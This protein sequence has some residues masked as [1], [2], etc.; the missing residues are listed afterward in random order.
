MKEYLPFL[1]IGITA[2]S[3][4]GLAA[5][6]LVLT[7]KTSGIFN[8]AH[9]AQAAM[10]AYLMFEFHERMGMPWPLA[11]L[12]SLLLAGVVAGL[13]LER[14]AYG[15]ASVGTAARVA[16]TV[17]LLVAIQGSL[18]VAFGSASIGMKI[19]L[20]TGIVELPGVN[21]R[22]DQI[23]VTTFVLLAVVSLYV[24]FKRTKLGL[25]M[26][27]VVDDPALLG[28]QS[29]NPVRVRR[30]AWLIG[31]SFAAISGMVLAPTLGLDAFLLTLLV[32]YAYGAAAVGRF[33]SLPITYVGGL[34]I[35]VAAALLTKFLNT[36]GPIASLPATLPFLVLFAALL[37]VP[38]HHLIERGSQAVRRQLAPVAF[39][40]R[41]KGI[42][43]AAGAAVAV[44]IPGVVGTKLPLFTTALV[45]V[46]LFASLS[47]LVRMSG[48]V[49][50]CQMAFAAVGATTAARAVDAGV[51]FPL[52]VLLGGLVAVPIGGLLAIP[53]IRLSGVYLAIA[54]FGFGLLVQRLF[55]PSFLMFGKDY[56]L[57]A[58]RPKL[59]GLN[60]HT[61]TGYYFVVL[62]GMV[63][64][65]G[66][67]ALIRTSRMGRLLRAFADS[68]TA[69]NAHGTNTTELKVLVFCTSAFLAGIGGALL[70]PVTGTATQVSFDLGVSL[71]L[72]AVLF[73]AGRQPLLSAVVAAVLFIVIP[74]YIDNA[75]IREY[76]PIV[77][78][79]LAVVAAIYG[80]V[81]LLDRLAAAKL[82]SRRSTERTRLRAR[83]AAWGSPSPSA[84]ALSE[85][86]S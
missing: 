37:V 15:L 67:L 10:A 70:G 50:L 80:G 78:G 9:G 11:M 68:P 17:G 53:A 43:L 66:L 26:Q 84:P 76:T 12:L 29:I 81:P 71:L 75:G 24:F 22:I 59:G 46:I 6:G 14:V 4:Y 82:L 74:G 47:L 39:S 5:V 16:A 85:V 65:V 38:K 34:T 1:V 36:T 18:V 28:L 3:V 42:G 32:F 2:G 52:A 61:D 8:F 44:A 33:S 83:A 51:P 31:S 58:P 41:T 72:L 54:T 13:L 20:P 23:I 79:A 64:C 55:F 25:S 73:V 56:Y 69:L 40:R 86:A 60:V 27:A 48:Q 21:V 19:Y 77:F 35:G 57:A 49:S 30:F 45:Y 7:Y 63:L 62:A